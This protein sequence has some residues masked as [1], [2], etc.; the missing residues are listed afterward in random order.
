MPRQRRFCLGL[1]TA[2]VFALMGSGSA[3][4]AQT[5]GP[6]NCASCFGDSYTLTMSNEVVGAKTTTFDATLTINSS[7]FNA[8]GKGDIGVGDLLAASIK[9]VDGS[10][11]DVDKAKLLA[12]P[13]AVG[14]WTTHIGGENG[15]GCNGSGGGFVCSQWN[16]NS[17]TD[18]DLGGILTF[19]WALT[20][21][22]GHI[23]TGTLDSSVKALFGCEEGS[24]ENCKAK[25]Q[26]SQGITLGPSSVP[27]P[28]TLVLLVWGTALIGAT[29]LLRKNLGA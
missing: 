11:G 2:V 26:T 20:V 24:G 4:R 10:N 12:A 23:A 19:E 1:T 8:F 17:E 29:T 15:N 14:D 27:E 25:P 21:K 5:I 28:T 6:N 13:V 9:V 16:S 18:A 3:A 7:G 22:N